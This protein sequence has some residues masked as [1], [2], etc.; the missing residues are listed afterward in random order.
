MTITEKPIEITSE[1][2]ENKLDELGARLLAVLEETWEL[3]Q[4]LEELR[5]LKTQNEATLKAKL[6]EF[7][8]A[9]ED[10]IL[11]QKLDE[12]INELREV[13]GNNEKIEAEMES[14]L[15]KNME[16]KKA[17]QDSILKFSTETKT[18]Q[19]LQTYYKQLEAT[20]NALTREKTDLEN[21]NKEIKE[22]AITL[23]KQKEEK[24]SRI[25]EL[26]K[27]VEK[28][29]RALYEKDLLLAQN[30][31]IIMMLSQKQGGDIDLVNVRNS[32]NINNF[33]NY[34]GY[35][36]LAPST[37]RERNNII[38]PREQI[39]D[40]QSSSDSKDKS[41]NKIED[42]KSPSRDTSQNKKKSGNDSLKQEKGKGSAKG[43][44]GSNPNQGQYTSV[45][46]KYKQAFQP[47][48]IQELKNYAEKLRNVNFEQVPTRNNRKKKTSSKIKKET[49]L[50]TPL[51]NLSNYQNALKA[52]NQKHD[53]QAIENPYK[54]TAAINR[55]N[56]RPSRERE[57]II[58]SPGNDKAN[59]KPSN[60]PNKT[61][62]FTDI[63]SIMPPN[64]E[65][66]VD[67]SVK[68]LIL[69][70][71]YSSNKEVNSRLEN[72]NRAGQP[73]FHVNLATLVRNMNKNSRFEIQREQDI[74]KPANQEET[75]TKLKSLN[76]SD[77]KFNEKTNAPLQKPST[78]ESKNKKGE[79]PIGTLRMKYWDLVSE[80][81]K[82]KNEIESI[83]TQ[84]VSQSTTITVDQ[85]KSP[86]RKTEEA[87][88][89]GRAHV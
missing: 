49:F 64:N 68:D 21:K 40:E 32:L 47:V 79:S 16:E 56:E 28:L 26:E 71:L 67:Y 7:E 1:V 5:E 3:T 6:E 22:E 2:P 88:Q 78:E 83:P 86:L 75:L 12:E 13:M 35:F 54:I 70:N 19:N 29:K 44:D 34:N 81:N 50:P 85:S 8:L 80:N 87:S 66:S 27:Q 45:R 11:K 25:Q 15:R 52:Q 82:F 57:R 43:P 63:S 69:E 89:I 73:A 53:V 39:S 37:A 30:Q 38:I 24:E 4:S 55:E 84:T 31:Q 60:S 61:N 14:N 36:D 48:S 33:N 62:P 23:A 42:N 18:N 77:F 17:I 46:N 76:E 20:C 51:Q 9:K 59:L 65:H 10:P 72:I 58:T 41:P 74:K